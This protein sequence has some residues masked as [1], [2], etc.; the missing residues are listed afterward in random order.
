M[1]TSEIGAERSRRASRE[2]HEQGI[3]GLARVNLRFHRQRNGRREPDSRKLQARRG[4]RIGE[5]VEGDDALA[6]LLGRG[7]GHVERRPRP[8]AAPEDAPVFDRPFQPATRFPDAAPAA[9]GTTPQAAAP[10]NASQD[11]G[12]HWPP[13]RAQ[14]RPPAQP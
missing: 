3:S 6:E 9:P 11:R 14:A 7:M 2:I 5:D 10:Q 12:A 1:S 8:L 4:Q 13:G